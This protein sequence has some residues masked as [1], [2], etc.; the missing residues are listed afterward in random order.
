MKSSRFLWLIYAALS[1]LGIFFG[2]R[3]L[4]GL[5]DITLGVGCGKFCLLGN[6][7]AGLLGKWPAKVILGSVFLGGGIYSAL[8]AI[9]TFWASKQ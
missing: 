3:Y 7:V 6:V 8:I 9:R 2:I 5:E 4:L 1:L